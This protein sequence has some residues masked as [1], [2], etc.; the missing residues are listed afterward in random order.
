MA[1]LR[2]LQLNSITALWLT[3]YFKF[4]CPYSN[5]IGDDELSD[6]PRIAHASGLL[7]KPIAV[8][9]KC[10]SDHRSQDGLEVAKGKGSGVIL[11]ARR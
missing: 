3:S 9:G 1:Y 5:L 6:I 8:D 10:K 2:N 4:P 11:N 7:P